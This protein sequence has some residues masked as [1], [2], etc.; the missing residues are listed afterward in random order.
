MARSGQ[1]WTQRL[2]SKRWT[3]L[4]TDGDRIKIVTTLTCVSHPSA[5]F[6]LLVGTIVKIISGWLDYFCRIKYV[7]RPFEQ[8]FF[9]NKAGNITPGIGC[10]GCFCVMPCMH[11]FNK[12][13]SRLQVF[14]LPKL[15][16]YSSDGVPITINGQVHY[17]IL[18]PKG[19]V[20]VFHYRPCQRIS[21]KMEIG[22]FICLTPEEHMSF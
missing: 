7:Q 5:K 2:R 3:Q 20:L 18:N 13:D 8:G 22:R 6:M 1:V 10:C 16:I 12:F 17:R 11:T 15:H 21:R 14:D 4:L 9:T 19:M